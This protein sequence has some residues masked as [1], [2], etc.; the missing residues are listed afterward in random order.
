MLTVET[1]LALLQ[2][3][4]ATNLLKSAIGGSAKQSWKINGFYADYGQLYIFSI[5]NRCANNLA[6]TKSKI[7]ECPQL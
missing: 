6:N 5:K 2:K 3:P 1:I 4:T 7:G